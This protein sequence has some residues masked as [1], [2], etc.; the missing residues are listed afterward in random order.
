MK[1]EQTAKQA[2]ETVLAKAGCS[3]NRD[4]IDARIVKEVR[5]STYTYEGSNRD[6]DKSKW[7]LKGLIDTPDDVGGWPEYKGTQEQ[8]TDKDGIPDAWETAHGLNPEDPTDAKAT[9]LS[10]PYINL[11]VYLND[12]VSH[13]Y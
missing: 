10:E 5:D 2:Y 11:E 4:V 3:L 9:T 6:V 8:D 1:D 7:S 12:I 13:L